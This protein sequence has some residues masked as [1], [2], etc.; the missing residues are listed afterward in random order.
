MNGVSVCPA[1]FLQNAP[2]WRSP[3]PVFGGLFWGVFARIFLP[4]YN[5]TASYSTTPIHQLLIYYS[6]IVT[7]IIHTLFTG[8]LN[9]TSHPHSS[10]TK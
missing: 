4:L 2:T 5:L 9:Y 6:P 3:N 8:I 10:H 7:Q 1:R